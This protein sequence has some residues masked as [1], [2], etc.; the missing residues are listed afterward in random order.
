MRDQLHQHL[1]AAYC[2]A[3]DPATVLCKQ[4]FDSVQRDGGAQL[5]KLV[6]LGMHNPEDF[7]I[8]ATRTGF[9]LGFRERLATVAA[10]L[11]RD[12]VASSALRE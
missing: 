4:T 9:V 10:A 8:V 6:L 12:A 1:Q 7:L 5:L 11:E 2:V 3:N